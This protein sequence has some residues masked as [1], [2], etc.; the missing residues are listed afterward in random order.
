MRAR[1]ALLLSAT[2]FMGEAAAGVIYKCKTPEGG[3][4]YQENPCAD[5]AKSVSSW[6]NAGGAPLVINQGHQGHYFIDGS[7]NDKPLNFVV[8]TGA[9][10]V[11][12]PQTIAGK[13]GLA[14]QRK[15]ILRTGNGNTE[16]CTTTITSL[17]FGNFTF[18]NIEAIVA[19]NLDQPLLGMNVLKQFR[20]EQDSGAMRLIWR[21]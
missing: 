12:L 2:F 9:S 16:A 14:C 15:A 8:D 20:I 19:P 10:I 7:V 5:T 13:A 1:L 6:G 3:L 17:K 21:D 18:K 4:L 11:S